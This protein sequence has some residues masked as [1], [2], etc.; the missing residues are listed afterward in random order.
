MIAI[1][2]G[3]EKISFSTEDAPIEDRKS[4]GKLLIPLAKGSKIIDLLKLPQQT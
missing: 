2:T 3:N 1:I 4:I